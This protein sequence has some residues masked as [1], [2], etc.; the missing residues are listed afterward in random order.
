MLSFNKSSFFISLSV[1]ISMLFVHYLNAESL[2]FEFSFNNKGREWGE[3]VILR[4]LE[5][6]LGR[7][8]PTFNK[9]GSD[10]FHEEPKQESISI[11]YKFDSVK[12]AA[13]YLAHEWSHV[14]SE[15]AIVRFSVLIEEYYDK[16]FKIYNFKDAGS[17]RPHDLEPKF[18]K[19]WFRLCKAEILDYK[20]FSMKRSSVAADF[21]NRVAEWNQRHR[22]ILAVFEGD[23]MIINQQVYYYCA[24]HRDIPCGSYHPRIDC[25]PFGKKC[26]IINKVC[27]VYQICKPDK[28]SQTIVYK[29]DYRAFKRNKVT[30]LTKQ[31]ERAIPYKPA[32]LGKP[33]IPPA[34]FF[35]RSTIPLNPAN[36]MRPRPRLGLPYPRYQAPVQGGSR[37][38]ARQWWP[39]QVWP[40]RPFWNKYP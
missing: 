39:V 8:D 19:E 37:W 34:C 1:F 25:S 11:T 21:V 33:Y 9:S 12:V 31:G 22:N 18:S 7:L 32:T 16:T 26:C 20:M 4:T 38:P 2:L 5:E 13:L 40:P 24:K 14:R 27:L 6:D 3:V 17:G 35:N 10:C 23:D 29:P 15:K 28:E 30:L 36:V